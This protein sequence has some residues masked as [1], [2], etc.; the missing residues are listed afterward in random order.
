MSEADLEEVCRV[1]ITVS[2]KA[3][4]HR[5]GERGCN[6]CASRVAEREVKEEKVVVI[7]RSNEGRHNS[8]L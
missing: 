1:Q 3:N 7:S 2:H 5:Y 6:S 8:L 4:G